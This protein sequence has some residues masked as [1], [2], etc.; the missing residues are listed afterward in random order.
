[1]RR[2]LRRP[3]LVLAVSA[4][5]VGAT[6]VPATA[7]EDNGKKIA[8]GAFHSL[9]VGGAVIAF[10]AASPVDPDAEELW[11]SVRIFAYAGGPSQ[12]RVYCG[13]VWNVIVTLPFVSPDAERSFVDEIFVTQTLDNVVVGATDETAVRWSSTFGILTQAHGTFLAPGTLTDGTHVV[14]QTVEHPVFGIFWDPPPLEF[15]VNDTAC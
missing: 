15:E 5:M 12:G 7:A 4:I 8:Q 13:D 2:H 6:V 1:M 10:G 11:D 9:G 14:K 3:F